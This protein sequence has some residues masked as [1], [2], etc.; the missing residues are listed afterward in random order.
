MPRKLFAT[1][2]PTRTAP[3]SP[4]PGT[5]WMATI[6]SAISVTSAST[7]ERDHTPVIVLTLA[8]YLT[9]AA[10]WSRLDLPFSTPQLWPVFL[11]TDISLWCGC[12]CTGLASPLLLLTRT[13][14]MLKWVSEQ[15]TAN[16][17]WHQAF[18][19]LCRS[20]SLLWWT[21]ILPICSGHQISIE[22]NIKL[23][24]S[25]TCLEFTVSIPI[26]Y[27]IISILTKKW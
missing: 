16:N 21:C 5:L 11:A 2:K 18:T 12:M 3:K 25:Q 1:L 14:S 8:P 20:K 24:P 15:R 6:A 9:Q 10:V 23:W 4:S 26:L 19:S 22:V 13:R 27:N 17:Y 7:T